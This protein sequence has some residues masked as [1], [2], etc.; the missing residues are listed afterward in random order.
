MYFLFHNKYKFSEGSKIT[1]F[2]LKILS[3]KDKRIFYNILFV[4]YYI[5][6]SNRLSSSNSGTLL[7]NIK[8]SNDTVFKL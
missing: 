7:I 3:F 4:G 6:I 5:H 8:Y 2:E 1:P